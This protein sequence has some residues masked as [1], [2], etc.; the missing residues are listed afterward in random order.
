MAATPEIPKP[1]MPEVSER[2]EQFIVPEQLQQTTGIKVVQK[3]FT[4]QVK[5]DKGQP[6][7]AATPAQVINV[8][9]PAG[10]TTL[11]SWSKGPISSSITWLGMFWLRIIKK[12]VFFGW[13]VVS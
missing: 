12:A 6:L 4:A 10:Q 3:T 7:I 8:T 11:L 2:A 9:P 5:G 13:K 1:E